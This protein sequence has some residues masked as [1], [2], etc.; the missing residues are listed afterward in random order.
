M[1]VDLIDPYKYDRFLPGFRHPIGLI[2][3]G[4]AAIRSAWNWYTRP[5]PSVGLDGAA[6]GELALAGAKA[7]PH[8]GINLHRRCRF[9]IYDSSRATMPLQAAKGLISFPH[10]MCSQPVLVLAIADNQTEHQA[11]ERFQQISRF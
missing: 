8:D 5:E 4:K 2:S 3:S 11:T 6:T 9:F 10:I 7:R 1:I